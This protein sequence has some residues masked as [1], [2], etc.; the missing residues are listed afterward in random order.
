MPQVIL[1]N[2]GKGD[3]MQIPFDEVPFILLS[4]REYQCHQGKNKS[5][6][7]KTKKLNVEKISARSNPQTTHNTLK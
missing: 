6:S 1:Q 7:K 3:P 2:R 4:T 5:I